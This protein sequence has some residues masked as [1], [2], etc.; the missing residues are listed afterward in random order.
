MVPLAPESIEAL[1]SEAFF[2]TGGEDAH[3]QLAYLGEMSSPD[4]WA[5]DQLVPLTPGSTSPVLSLDDG[6]KDEWLHHLYVELAAQERGVSATTKR[7][8]DGARYEERW[9]NDESQ[10]RA[11]L[12]I[13]NVTG[14]LA[15]FLGISGGGDPDAEAAWRQAA[16]YATGAT[17][18]HRE[19]VAW[20]AVVCQV[21]TGRGLR[22][23]GLR[24]R[25]PWEGAGLKVESSHHLLTEEVRSWYPG[26]GY[27]PS[28]WQFWPHH[29]GG[30][31]DCYDWD[32]DGIERAA[33]ILR[34]L[35]EVLTLAWDWPM[36][37]RVGPSATGINV[38]GDEKAVVPGLSAG[39]VAEDSLIRAEELVALPAWT[40]NAVGVQTATPLT[41]ALAAHY[42]A[43]LLKSEHPSLALIGFVASIETLAA[44]AGGKLPRCP[45]CKALQGSG[46]R[47][48]D[49]VAAVL[50]PGELDLLGKAYD[51]RSRTAHDATLHGPES[52]LGMFPV[53][54]LFLPDERM[55]FEW[56]TVHLAAKASRAL[57]LAEF[58][59]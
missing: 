3:R 47:F 29:V 49:A 6:H 41:R 16:V 5:P 46:Q 9:F 55:H 33:E 11:R 50:T 20:A 14:G 27:R 21:P 1:P 25:E 35:V 45:E 19:S 40:N 24:L 22:R 31:V 12:I 10:D 28:F 7:T 23:M 30:T 34:R 52:V 17:A 2:V 15:A 4:D 42:E 8:V 59:G 37:V 58:E 54:R 26:I 36:E 44:A 56:G 13:F 51:R 57:L 53:P 43:S 18:Q 38:A 48:K 32:E 39:A